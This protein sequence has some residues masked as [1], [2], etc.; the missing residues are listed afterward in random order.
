MVNVL[1]PHKAT[2]T[3]SYPSQTIIQYKPTGCIRKSIKL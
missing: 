3:K 1:D 2:P